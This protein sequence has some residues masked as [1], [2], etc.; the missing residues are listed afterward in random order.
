MRASAR[1]A[2]ER[3]SHGTDDDDAVA[4]A[5]AAGGTNGFCYQNLRL[6]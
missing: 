3:A 4:A 6:L 5:A 2:S 1:R